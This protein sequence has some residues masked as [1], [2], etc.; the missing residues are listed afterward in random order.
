MKKYVLKA[1]FTVFVVLTGYQPVLADCPHFSAGRK[2]GTIESASISE[3]SGIAASRK[4]ANI[5]WIHNDD[6]PACVYAMTP[7]GKYLGRYILDGAHNRDW[8]DIAIGPGPDPNVD[9]LYIG[10][11]GDNVSIHKSIKIYRVPEPLVDANQPPAFVKIGDVETIELVYPNGPRNGETLMID[12]LTKDIYVISKEE[13]SRVYRTAWPQSTTSQTTLE[14]VAKLPSGTATGGD[15]SPDGRMIIVRGYFAASLWLRPEKAPL[16]QCFDK[17]ECKVP[18][19]F[20]RQGEGICFDANG[21]GYYTTSEHRHQPI[22]YF[23]KE[24]K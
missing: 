5:L 23:P 21:A 12:P 11:I 18:L 24:K 10:D 17:T 13:P 2:V 9:Y 6:G 1:A 16:W 19:I 15:I 7:Q 20:E 14:Y 3:A 8:E 4:N 22:Y